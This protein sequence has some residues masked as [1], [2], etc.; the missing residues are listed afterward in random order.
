MPETQIKPILAP[1]GGLNYSLPA[2]LISELEMS[3]GQNVFF[4]D[5]KVKKR[6]GY[7]TMGDN[8]PLDGAIVGID[9]FYDFQGNNWLLV[10]TENE[11]YKWLPASSLWSKI[12][13]DTFTGTDSNFFS[14]DYVRKSTETNPWWVCTNGVDKIKKFTGTGTI[15]DLITDYPA[16]VTS[17]LAKYLAEFKTYLILMDVTEQGN[18]Y[19]QRVR[20]SD[21]ADPED[22]ING[23]A[24]YQDLSGADWIVGGTKFKGDYFVVFKERS[25]WVSYATGDSD[26]F[27]FD[28]KITGTG[29]SAGGTIE[30]LGDEL[31]FLGWDDVYVFNG[32]DYEPIGTPIQRKL[33][34]TM[35]PEEMSRSF[36]VVIEE[37]KEYWLFLPSTNKSHISGSGVSTYPDIAWCFNYNLN[38]WTRH[39]YNDFITG[40]GYYELEATMTIDDL[41][42]T[43][44]QQTWKFDDR[45]ILQTAPI[46]LFGDKDG[47]VYQYDRL[48]NNEDGETIDAWFST[49]DFN[50]T[51][52]M[53]RFRL[54][55]IDVYYIGG[56]L[57]V[58][59]STDKGTTWTDIGTLSESRNFE[60]PR[61][62]YCRAD[63]N[64][65]RLRFRN[66][67]SGE[68]FEFSR[69]NIYWQPAGRRL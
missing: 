18:R 68:H 44:D 43:I 69:A 35:N 54:L 61:S 11:I 58:A 52:L 4:E 49:K 51:Q 56:S 7:T 37:Q 39:S 13:D 17:L 8:L 60:T 28:Q 2:D 46:N 26:I 66:N 50:P 12:T 55:R 6:Y 47:Y 21:T 33:F 31:I 57:N 62:L 23:N 19:P 9:Q 45:T 1:R 40:Y 53:Q 59:Y 48:V 22:F 42:G 15:S 25:V 30:S 41:I 65:A 3:D 14:Y 20:W 24:N 32:I 36:G 27:Q 38:K 34:A 5:G 16:G 10:L 63:M 64:M 29:C 67:N